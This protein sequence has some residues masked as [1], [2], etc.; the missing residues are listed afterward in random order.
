MNINEGTALQKKQDIPTKIHNKYYKSSILSSIY[1]FFLFILIVDNLIL[2]S[3]S[4][5]STK[6][7]SEEKGKKMF[8][9]NNKDGLLKMCYKSRTM[10]YTKNRRKTVENYGMKYDENNLLTINDKLNYL[11]I[12][13]SPDYKSKIC[14]KI[15]LHEYS[16]NK[17]GKDICV[18]IIKIYKDINEINLKELP[19]KFVLKCNHGS[20]MN[21]LC[22]N[23]EKFDIEQAKKSLSK[24]IN[25]DYGFISNEF[26]Y[27]NIKREIF[28]ESY[29]GENILDYKVY[30]F[31]GNPKFI[32][33][34][35]KMND[36][37][38]IN[39]YYD[40]EWNLTDIETGLPHFYRKPE[41][42]FEKPTNLETMIEY[43]KKLSDEFVF[44]RVDFYN[45]NGNIYLGELTFSPSNNRMRFKDE[46]QR[47]YLGN[48]LDI[49]KIKNYLYNN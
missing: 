48:L 24:W 23:K 5:N 38:K 22:N 2:R 15:R 33:V 8:D 12:H 9:N 20:E 37:S 11:L 4:K 30:C 44:V 43:A 13:E 25:M 14:D 28:A 36:S 40:L 49:T 16:K 29:L 1:L 45:I 42:R 39:N 17:L 46:K 3:K 35:K 27:I 19:N 18:P 34:Q 31:N 26:Q 10:Y 6:I 7:C 32:R 47:I 41:V 21:I